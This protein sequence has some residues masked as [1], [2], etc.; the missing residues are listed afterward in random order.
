MC[1][2]EQGRALTRFDGGIKKMYEQTPQWQDIA[3]IR[4]RWKGPL[5]IKGILRADDARRAVDEGADAIVV[6]NHGG[7]YMDG[8]MPSLRALPDV[9]A[10]VGHKTEV[11]FDS[12]IRR[13]IDVIRAMALGARA[14]LLGRAYVWPHLAAG[15]AGVS[16]ILELFRQQI[17][18]GLAYLGVK[19]IHDL[20]RSHLDITWPRQHR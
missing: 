5:I 11:L 16:H 9:V 1:L 19:S 20:D 2:D 12:G 6:S 3:W 10:A 18:D 4:Q 8:S 17:D 15:E 7:N 14:V 13:G